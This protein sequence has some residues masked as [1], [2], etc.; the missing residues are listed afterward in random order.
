LKGPLDL[1]LQIDDGIDI[2]MRMYACVCLCVGAGARAL[3]TSWL[4]LLPSGFGG[5][6]CMQVW[7]VTTQ[8][9]ANGKHPDPAIRQLSSWQVCQ[10]LFKE[11]GLRWLWKVGAWE[12]GRLGA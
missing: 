9:L 10:R 4:S 8:L 1:S 11:S 6:G 2:C 5:L 3:Q 7:V 12:V